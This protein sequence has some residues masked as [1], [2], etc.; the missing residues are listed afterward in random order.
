LDNYGVCPFQNKIPGLHHLRKT[1]E[2]KFCFPIDLHCFA[3]Q[4]D[5]TILTSSSLKRLVLI[6]FVISL[7]LV[8]K[9]LK[10]QLIAS[11][12]RKKWKYIERKQKNPRKKF[13]GH[14]N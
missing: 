13:Q 8:M 3:K 2:D 9:V 5:M 12:V 10:E 11:L 4:I 1:S 14:H 7:V 6:W